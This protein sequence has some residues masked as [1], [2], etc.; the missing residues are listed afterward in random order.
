MEGFSTRS[1][2]RQSYHS[3]TDF[4]RVLLQLVETLLSYRQLS[5]VI[6][7]FRLLMKSCAQFNLL[8]MNLQ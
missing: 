5:F 7:I 1:H 3:A 2:K 8:V 6:E 4:N